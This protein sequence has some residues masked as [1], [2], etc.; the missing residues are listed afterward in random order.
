MLSQHPAPT[1]YASHDGLPPIRSFE[2][3]LRRVLFFDRWGQFAIACASDLEFR[4][5]RDGNMDSHMPAPVL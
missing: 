5:P 1:K 2:A 3:I 4:S